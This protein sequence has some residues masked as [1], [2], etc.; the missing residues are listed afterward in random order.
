MITKL[1]N[2][3][4]VLWFC[5]GCKQVHRITTD[6]WTWN[7]DR[8]K[9]TFQPSVLVT[10]G[11]LDKDMNPVDRVCHSFVKDGMMQFLGDCTHELAG[12][13]VPIPDWPWAPGTFGGVQD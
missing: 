4:S 3:G 12:Q 10:Q 5:P 2:D 1:C 9:P 13:T 7:G 8:D 6:L 11:R